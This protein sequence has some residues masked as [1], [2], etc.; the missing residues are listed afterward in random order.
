MSARLLPEGFAAAVAG[1]LAVFQGAE[2]ESEAASSQAPAS[3]RE[4]MR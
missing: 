4:L 1:V 2:V 3:Y